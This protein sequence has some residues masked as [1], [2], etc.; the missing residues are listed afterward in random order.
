MAPPTYDPECE[1]TQCCPLSQSQADIHL[2]AVTV[3]VTLRSTRPTTLATRKLFLRPDEPVNVGR[4]SRSEAKNLSA[5]AENALFDCPVVSRQHAE[6]ELRVNKWTEE[7]HHVYIKDTSSM[8]GTSVN[9]Q[10]LQPLKPFQL[11]KGDIIRLG[12][13]VNRADSE[14][15]YLGPFSSSTKTSADN[16]DGVT[17]SLDSISTATKKDTTQVKSSQPGI[18]VPS[19]SESDFDDD[20]NDS[21]GGADL[22]PSSAHTTPDQLTAKSELKSSMKTGSSPSNGIMV[23]DED[24]EEP[25]TISKRR[26]YSRQA[27][28]PDTYAD[29]SATAADIFAP[30][31][32]SAVQQSSRSDENF[33][34]VL[35]AI[36]SEKTAEQAL[37]DD[38]SF[39]QYPRQGQPLADV[40]AVSWSEQSNVSD[41]EEDSDEH[42]E[43]RE[44]FDGQSFLSEEF[45]MADDADDADDADEM[46]V[47]DDE[48]DE[49]PEIM[50]SKRRPSN[51]LGT[52]GDEHTNA[53]SD[54][55]REAAIPARPHYDPVRGFQVSNSSIDKN[56][57]YRSYES[58]FAPQT[59]AA[60]TNSDHRAKWDV[61]P[62]NQPFL[63]EVVNTDIQIPYAPSIDDEQNAYAQNN[64]YTFTP[65]LF[66]MP[67]AAT[68]AN[69][70]G[71]GGGHAFEA[72][73]LMSTTSD[74]VE[75]PTPNEFNVSSLKFRQKTPHSDPIDASAEINAK[76][77]KAPEMTVDEPT[78]AAEVPVTIEEASQ[79]AAPAITDESQAKKRKIKQPRS[80][81]SVLRTAV[82]EAGKY[83][84]GAIIGGIGLVTLLA[85]PIGEALASC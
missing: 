28:I 57:V 14:C 73:P 63:P 81:K 21:D 66:N 40:E 79:V 48:D 83:T 61:G 20:D 18:S 53:L 32:Y 26:T 2:P 77:R 68:Q 42:S 13:S 10:K 33:N 60:F 74:F 52:L 50:S 59:I 11:Q 80:Q 1:Y 34:R 30:V 43:S 54:T 44:D 17:L 35:K 56:P 23:E 5:T 41:H 65:S 38:D 69:R 29:D 12:E 58:V 6:L 7:K 78:I 49:G 64:P 31:P 72:L 71:L 84:A 9:G 45:N 62:M 82:I 27:V 67:P 85:S 37:K 3:T 76:K 51:E 8:H 25:V 19:D 46:A 24:D 75:Q 22:H 39:D 70:W 15:C 4:S 36:V 55:T 47:E 16:Y